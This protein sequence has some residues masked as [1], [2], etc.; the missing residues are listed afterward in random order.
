M[1]SP[2]PDLLLLPED[3]PTVRRQ[4]HEEAIQLK[5]LYQLY[6]LDR[7]FLADHEDGRILYFIDSHDIKAFIDPD[8]TNN[9]DG[10]EIG[11][12][13]LLRT[14]LETAGG[15]TRPMQVSLRHNQ[16]L[17]GLLFDP[18]S[19][20]GVLPS[21]GSELDREVTHQNEA[22]CR[23][24]HSDVV[25]ERGDRPNPRAGQTLYSLFEVAGRP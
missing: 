17:N 25:R 8:D 5:Q 23:T 3:L 7:E 15:L 19:L 14:Q 2:E 12:E 10:F 22:C 4:L 11:V 18:S 21:H 20:A 6:E 24:T 16:I 13:R 9:M 1:P